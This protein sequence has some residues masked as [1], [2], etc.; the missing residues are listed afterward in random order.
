MLLMLA[1]CPQSAPLTAREELIPTHG[2]G[3][4]TNASKARRA[5]PI[6]ICP[7]FHTIRANRPAI[8][9]PKTAQKTTNLENL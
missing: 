3:A 1:L 6:V 2:Q 9:T 5:G 4:P 8:F 7:K